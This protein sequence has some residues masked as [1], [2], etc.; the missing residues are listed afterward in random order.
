[1]HL[2]TGEDGKINGRSGVSDKSGGKVKMNITNP[3]PEQISYFWS[4]NKFAI[5]ER[6][7]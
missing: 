1:M 2:Y 6:K 5:T 7:N 4:S 3:H